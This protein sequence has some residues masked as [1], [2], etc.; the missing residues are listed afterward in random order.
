MGHLGHFRCWPTLHRLRDSRSERN[1]I[2]GVMGMPFKNMPPPRS[3]R[4]SNT[5]G[6]A[7]PQIR[8]FTISCNYQGSGLDCPAPRFLEIYDTEA[9]LV[10]F[11]TFVYYCGDTINA[12]LTHCSINTTWEEI[13]MWMGNLGSTML[14]SWFIFSLLKYLNVLLKFDELNIT[15]EACPNG[16]VTSGRLGSSLSSWTDSWNY[17]A[18]KDSAIGFCQRQYKIQITMYLS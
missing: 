16:A 8:R 9:L 18:K 12:I 2:S 14:R 1:P 17:N 3:I 10:T 6:T 11:E 7:C 5:L 13:S 15:C 4:P